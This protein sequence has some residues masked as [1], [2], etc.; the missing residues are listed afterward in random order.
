MKQIKENKLDGLVELIS[1][2]DNKTVG[3]RDGWKK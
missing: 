2:F 1:H 3:L